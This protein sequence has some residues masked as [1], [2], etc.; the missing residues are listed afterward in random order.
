MASS[1]IVFDR[2]VGNI[3]NGNV[4]LGSDTCKAY[5]SNTTPDKEQD[6]YKSDL[7]EIGAGNGY[8]AGGVT[9]TS[10]TWT[11]QAGSP[12]GVW[13]FDSADFSWTASGGSIGPAQYLVI[14]ALGAGSPNEFL[15][16]YANYG[17]AFTITDGNQLLVTVANGYFEIAAAAGS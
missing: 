3:G 13:V 16:G 4:K 5:L 8:T 7:A 17:S 14:Y 11:Q 10:V 15:L 2:T 12:Q 1:F 6:Q 9:L